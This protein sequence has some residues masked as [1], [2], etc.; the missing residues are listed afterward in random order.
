ML[1]KLYIPIAARLR[2]RKHDII[3]TCAQ[4]GTGVGVAL[5]AKELKQHHKEFPHENPAM[6][7]SAMHLTVSAASGAVIG[8][9]SALAVIETPT[10]AMAAV[11]TGATLYFRKKIMKEKEAPSEHKAAPKPK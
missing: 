6:F 4:I 7:E 8:G 9:A 11:A 3:S 10:I 1:R 5:G 2:T